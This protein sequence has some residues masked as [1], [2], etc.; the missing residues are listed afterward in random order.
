[1]DRRFFQ[2][3]SLSLALAA[4]TPPALAQQRPEPA[5]G[6]A[7]PAQADG[8][9]VA[10]RSRIAELVPA[11]Q[12]EAQAASQ[13]RELLK[14]AR[15]AKAL[16]P[17][18]H[19][20]LQ[21]LH[22][23][24]GRL[25]PHAVRFNERAVHWNWEVNLI[26]SKQVN[27]LCMPGGKIVFYTGILDTLKLTDDEVAIV[28]GHEIAHA[29]REHGRERA[30]KGALAQG[31]TVGASILSQLFGFGDIGGQ[32]ASGAARLTMLKFGRD[33]EV[34][35][36]LVG[37]DIAARAG[38]DPRAGI[39]LWQKMAAASKGQPPQWLSTHPS[40]ET[41]IEEIRRNLQAT[42]PV[43]ARTRGVA[44]AAL[45]PYRSNTGQAVR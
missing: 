31:L 24:A 13:Y 7:A 39:V 28:M 23:I 43:Y 32:L 20:Q 19:P 38:F 33:D 11:E 40:H 36:D 25:I 29:L 9:A 1:M 3:L 34:E 4:A 16:A 15:S 12:V 14:Q 21:R 5:A 37:M 8:I 45:P 44:V 42:L 30:G 41:R 17:E 6:Q 2:A 18:N 22:R 27:A 35:A 10:P 26:A